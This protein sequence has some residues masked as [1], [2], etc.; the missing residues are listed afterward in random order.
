MWTNLCGQ[1]NETFEMKTTTDRK[2]IYVKY[3]VFLQ[4]MDQILNVYRNIALSK[5]RNI[6]IIV[7][8]F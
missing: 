6:R 4:S 5:Q 8:P 7:L 3:E 2:P 1:K